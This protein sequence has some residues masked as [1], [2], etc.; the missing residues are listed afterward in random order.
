MSSSVK[1]AFEHV[2]VQIRTA[3][4]YCIWS[5]GSFYFYAPY[6]ARRVE[7]NTTLIPQT[8]IR[9]LTKGRKVSSLFDLREI[10]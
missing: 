1:E 6:G 7:F 4:A 3:F 9:T 8:V 5:R 10:S 2:G